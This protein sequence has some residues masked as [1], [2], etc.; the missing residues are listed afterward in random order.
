MHSRR[1]TWLF[2]SISL[3][4][5]Q[6]SVV[7][8]QIYTSSGST[9]SDGALSFPNAKPGDIIIFNPA[10]FSPPLDPSHDGIFNFT[11]INIPAG[12][13]VKLSGQ[14][15]PV[16][17][18]WLASGNVDIEGTLDL[19]GGDGAA[20]T[21]LV[22]LR[23]ASIPGS[24]GYPGGVGGFVNTGDPSQPGLG[25]QGG[26]AGN[27]GVSCPVDGALGANL[28]LV[29]LFGGSGGGGFSQGGAFGGGGGAGG[30]AMLIASSA[31]IIVNG[32]ISANG[33]N[34]GIGTAGNSGA[35]GGS[36]GAVRLV[37]QTITGT[38]T[39]QVNG[40]V[41]RCS[42]IPS[43]GTI[44]LE[45]N[46]LNFSG[47]ASGNLTS[48]TPFATFVPSAGNPSPA[49]KVLTIGGVGV[50]PNPTG[51]FDT[52]D[53][54][55]NSNAAVPIVVQASNV[56]LGTVIHL[57]ITSENGNDILV[58]TPGLTGSLQSSTATVSVTFPPGYSHGYI[59]ASF[60]TGGSTTSNN[61]SMSS[62]IKQ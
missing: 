26:A 23:T 43:A 8:S 19:S 22:A 16:P 28:L 12:V 50:N 15:L 61:R 31:S 32:Q 46:Q 5:S 30:G 56:P 3:V 40:G 59:N 35:A 55:I 60:S 48:G 4:L 42:G 36:G 13:T 17:V 39:I 37:G 21:T 34:G 27:P 57:Q 52:P 53:V 49:V 2:F 62:V 14:I 51:S 6:S 33:G 24:G 54:T 18:Y 44:R 10:S 38:G 7:L 45:A 47:S 41:N 11:T 9:G 25:P 20:A 1:I 58:D 29:P